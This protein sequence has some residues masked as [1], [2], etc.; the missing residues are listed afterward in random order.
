MARAALAHLPT[1]RQS[2]TMRAT[3]EGPAH[4]TTAF[5]HMEGAHGDLMAHATVGV[6][7]HHA[8]QSWLDG[9]RPLGVGTV[10]CM[11]GD[12]R[13]A[14]Q[15]FTGV[16]EMVA[17]TAHTGWARPWVAAAPDGHPDSQGDQRDFDWLLRK[18]DAGAEGAIT[19]ALFD[20]DRFLVWRDRLARARPGFQWVAGVVPVREWT[21]TERFAQR[22][23]V[24]IPP[25]L[26]ARLAGLTP[27]DATRTARAH[28]AT[29]MARLGREGCDGVHV[30]TLNSAQGVEDLLEPVAAAVLEAA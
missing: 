7:E 16:L 19:Q 18:I 2:V 12:A 20:A 15:P 10:L 3:T 28:M 27:T 24:P 14:A 8:F 11:R 29:L 26:A 9:L 22:C 13:T 30:F 5:G 17:A 4:S 25:H 6:L 23:G 21:R 1:T